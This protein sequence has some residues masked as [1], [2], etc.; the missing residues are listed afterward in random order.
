MKDKKILVVGISYKPNIAD[1]RESPTLRLIE[2]LRRK[3]NL[4]YWH[5]PLVRTWNDESSSDLHDI[6]KMDFSI[7]SI[8]HDVIDREIITK[9]KS[10]VYDLTGTVK[11][12]KT[13]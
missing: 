9:S 12:I 13:F 2:E 7:I 4:V 11:E 5:D 6:S 3:G 8:L 10:E 1:I